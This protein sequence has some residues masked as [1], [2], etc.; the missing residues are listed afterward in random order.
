LIERWNTLPPAYAKIVSHLPLDEWID[1]LAEKVFSEPIFNLWV[2]RFSEREKAGGFANLRDPADP[3][4]RA[5]MEAVVE[6]N[7]ESAAMEEGDFQFDLV[8]MYGF[9]G[10]NKKHGKKPPRQ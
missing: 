4:T 6:Q 3:D 2:T 5:N 10:W 7:V 1:S 8:G 9:T